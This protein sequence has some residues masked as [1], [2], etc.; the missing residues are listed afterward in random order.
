MEIKVFSDMINA[1]E[2]VGKGILSIKDLQVRKRQH[3]RKVIDET[4][5]LLDS[6]IL[7]VLNRLSNLL[8][9]EKQEDFIRELRGLDNFTEWTNIERQVRLCNNLHT[10]G[11]EMEDLYNKLIDRISL[12]NPGEFQ[13]LTWALLY[14]G[15]AGLANFISKSLKNLSE[16]ADTAAQSSDDYEKVRKAVRKTRNALRKERLN[17]ISSEIKFI[18]QI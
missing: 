18:N 2:Q 8:L 16:M 13:N 4:Y 9:I 10:T 3:Y 1:L 17:L 5:R 6:A 12:R 7:L 15:E 14:E 11:R